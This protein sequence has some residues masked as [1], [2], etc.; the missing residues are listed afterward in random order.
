MRGVWY[1]YC[2]I[3]CF[4][5]PPPWTLSRSVYGRLSSVSLISRG[6][7]LTAKDR[8]RILVIPDLHC[9]I[10]DERA[11]DLAIQIK[12]AFKPERIV[13]LGDILDWAW[14]SE[15]FKN[16]PEATSGALKTE[17]DSF[18]KISN[19]LEAP[20]IDLLLGNHERRPYDLV[21]KYNGL[22]GTIEPHIIY[23]EFG[24]VPAR[25]KWHKTPDGRCYWQIDP[26]TNVIRIAH[27]K[28]TIVHG[29]I[30][31]KWAAHSAKAQMERWG[32]S[33][34]SGHSHRFAKYY[35]RDSCGVRVWVECGHLA[36]NPPPY[37]CFNDPAP[38]NWMQGVVTIET[39]GN[40]FHVNDIPFTLSYGAMF[41]GRKYKA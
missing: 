31:R 27:G 1:I 24:N 19:K 4:M 12:Q 3:I 20:H 8:E 16:D 41:N 9:S 36:K 7:F 18:R 2:D 40:Q 37:V 34:C 5:S 6:G 15:K 23:K 25:V 28:F 22:K 10:H 33:G 26:T 11:V 21:K 32:T 38:L 35:Q 13:F 17:L 29:G 39:E 30:V 14:A